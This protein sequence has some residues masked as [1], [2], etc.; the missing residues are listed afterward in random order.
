MDLAIKKN[1][2]FRLPVELLE[3]LKRIAKGQNRSLNNYVETV[4]LEAA[5]A[6]EPNRVTL[7]AM[8]EV[9]SGALRNEPALDLTSIE[10]MEKSMGL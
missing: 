8:K 3:S 1:Q 7:S 5:A 4:L 2:S 9:E 6:H 10:A